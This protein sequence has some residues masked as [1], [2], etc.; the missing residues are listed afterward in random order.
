MKAPIKAKFPVIGIFVIL[1]A[2]MIACGE[3]ATPRPAPTTDT[4]AIQQAIKEALAGQIQ[5]PTG[6]TAE[7]IAAQV[8]AAVQAVVPE[9]TSGE[10]I[11]AMVLAAVAA[12]TATAG[13]VTAEQ[14]QAVIAG[15]L[16]QQQP[17][18]TAADV[19]AA[20][21][22]AIA[23]L[24]TPIAVPT[25]EPAPSDAEPTGTLNVG[26][27]A[28]G[29]AL[30]LLKN[31]GVQQSRFDD[32]VTHEDMWWTSPTGKLE[33]RLVEEWEI[34]PSGKDFTFHFR[35]GVQFHDG[36]GEFTADDYLFTLQQVMAEGSIH[37]MAGRVRGMFFCDGC[38]VT[39]LDD[40]SVRLTRP[41]AT[42]Q[43]TW[44]ARGNLG[45]RSK[46]QIETL[47]EDL[48]NKQSVGTGPWQL[49]EVQEAQFKRVKAVRD[50]WRRTPEFDEMVWWELLEE[51]TRLANFLTGLLDTGTF[52]A[53]SIQAIKLEERPGVQFLTVPGG[54][55]FNLI[56]YGQQYDIENPNHVADADGNIRVALGDGASYTDTC[57]V[58]PWV[59]CDPD[60]ESEGWEKAR[61]VRVAMAI[62]INRQSL[63]NNLAFGDGKPLHHMFWSGHEGR[64]AEFGLD[65]LEYTYDP[66]RAR[67]LLTE[68]GYPDG[69]DL[70]LTLTEAFTA[71]PIAAGQ[72]VATMWED[73]GIRA[74][75]QLIPYPTWRPC[76][77]SRTCRAVATHANNSVVEPM[78]VFPLFWHPRSV[79][80]LG[81]EHPWFTEMTDKALSTVDD[82]ERWALQAEIGRWLHTNVMDMPLYE[83]NVLWPL[84]AKVDPWPI[85]TLGNIQL[86][87]WEL[88]RHKQ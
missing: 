88:A 83:A 66:D 67:Q 20:I 9:G 75:Q 49:V 28:L 78:R 64:R 3:A 57:T 7:E 43:I 62:S 12:A 50:H 79:F 15:A 72:A 29:P 63:V 77:V 26:M 18:L 46:L 35:E 87:N 1:L 24:P 33:S 74:K 11:Q 38:E 81:F 69:F 60:T 45:F 65:Q 44:N 17:G 37:T 52:T 56:L 30:F 2:L 58:L 48:A 55:M 51:S 59:S 25:V 71:G 6:P 86:G 47:G 19:E 36:W 8:Q 27:G 53:D 68:A 4:A 32:T 21:S 23:A 22:S 61:K 70:D 73:V 84:S 16:A 34:D 13:G 41:E 54:T 80:N 42:V 82:E 85:Q 40:Y 14:V 5:Q 76:T 39:K 10:D 31:Q